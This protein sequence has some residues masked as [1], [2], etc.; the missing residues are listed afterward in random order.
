MH[1]PEPPRHIAKGNIRGQVVD[2]AA[3]T[4]SKTR[5]QMGLQIL[6]DGEVPFLD[7]T[8]G[9]TRHTSHIG[10]TACPSDILSLTKSKGVVVWRT[11]RIYKTRKANCIHF[12]GKLDQLIRDGNVTK[13][14]GRLHSNIV[15]D[16]LTEKCTNASKNT[17]KDT[18]PKERPN[19]KSTCPWKSDEL[20]ALRKEVRSKKCRNRWAVPFRRKKVSDEYLQTKEKYA[21]RR[22][23]ERS[24]TFCMVA[25]I[26]K[27]SKL[28]SGKKFVALLKIN[29]CEIVATKCINK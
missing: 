18:T 6:S 14:V 28:L 24:I 19:T 20:E 15:L 25:A 7:T 17:C 3:A 11:A 8:R 5:H 10:V 16:P 29:Y 2:T 1:W 22:K 9:T 23:R 27:A 12:H 4:S 13:E 21:H 26:S